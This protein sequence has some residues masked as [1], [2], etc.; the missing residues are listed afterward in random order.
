MAV[1]KNKFD[2]M[3]TLVI[4]KLEGGYYHPQMLKDGRVKDARYSNSGETMFGIDR[5]AGGTLNDTASGKAFWNIV[6]TANASKTWKWNYK[7]GELAPKLKEHAT[8]IIYPQYEK[9][10][11]RYLTPQAKALV[12]SDSRLLF[13]FIYGTWN[14]SGWFK[15]FAEDINKAVASGV[16]DVN[17]LSQVAIDSRTKEGLR[18]GSPP[19]SLVAQG[20][21][22]IASLF[23]SM[24]DYATQG[25]NATLEGAKETVKKAKEN[26]I[27]TVALVVVV[28]V[29][30][31]VLYKTLTTKTKK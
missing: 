23:N 16:T 26:P 2:Q 7:G 27:I 21:N 5:K 18:A 19:D 22:K 4:D 17:K 20:G 29:A 15:K 6:D 31:Y 25:A 11:S 30:G 14:G 9:L 13:H 10:A 8:G 12:D 28:V 1:D 3:V 24:K